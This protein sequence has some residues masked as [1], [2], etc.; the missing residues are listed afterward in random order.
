MA[1]VKCRECGGDVSSKAETCPN[2]GVKVAKKNGLSSF[3]IAL[4][5]FVSIIYLFGEVEDRDKARESALSDIKQQTIQSQN[6]KP[7]ESKSKANKQSDGETWVYLSTNDELTGKPTYTAA[8]NSK[9]TV[10]FKW[11]YS[12]DQHA[13]L[14]LRTHPK[15]GKDAILSIGKGQFLCPSYKGCKIDARFDDGSVVSFKANPSSDHSSEVI[16]INDYHAFVEKLL[17]AKVVRLAADVYQEGRPAFVFDV[18][19]FDSDK[20]LGK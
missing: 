4:V 11:P 9:N 3:I 17:K 12:G 7:I 14:S 19:G 20:Y 6:S 13:L 15:Y 2:C 18:D 1:L 10:N 16:F 5:V 8:I